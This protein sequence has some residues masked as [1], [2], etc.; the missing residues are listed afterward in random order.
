MTKKT[1]TDAIPEIISLEQLGGLDR[2]DQRAL[3]RYINKIKVKLNEKDMDFR[4][5]NLSK[6][7][8]KKLLEELDNKN[9]IKSLDEKE[10]RDMLETKDIINTLER[11]DII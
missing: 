2:L 4:D 11:R 9:G 7:N 6:Y 5:F 1:S 3:T 10:I 8:A